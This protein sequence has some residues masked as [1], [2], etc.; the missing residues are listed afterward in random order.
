MA[1]VLLT[2]KRIEVD[3]VH[4]IADEIWRQYDF[5]DSRVAVNFAHKVGPAAERLHRRM[6]AAK[7]ILREI[8]APA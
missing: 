8:D 6:E 2:G 5:D 4:R 3:E 1:F 7:L